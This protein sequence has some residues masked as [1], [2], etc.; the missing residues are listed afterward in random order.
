MS[1]EVFAMNAMENLDQRI[2]GKLAQHRGEIEK[3]KNHLGQQM[4]QV[5]ARHQQFTALADRLVQEIVRPRL[6]KLVGYFDN[7][8]MQSAE[9]SG[10]HQ[11]VCLF[12]HT[13]RFPARARLEISLCHDKQAE[14]LLLS[15][16]LEILPIFFDFPRQD[17]LALPLKTVDDAKV[18]AWIEEKIVAFLDAYLRLETH[19]SYQSDNM[20][21]DLVCGMPVNKLH[22]AAQ[23]VHHGVTYYFCVEDC[24]KKFAEDPERYIIGKKVSP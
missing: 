13:D 14:N 5:E 4:V 24:R 15:Y 2:K 23:M 8:A 7:A 21:T 9:E 3:H 18:A 12:K 20:A 11:G 1:G 19:P 6:E 22:A 16:C 10:R 17:E